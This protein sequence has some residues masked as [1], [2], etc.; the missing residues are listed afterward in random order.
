VSDQKKASLRPVDFVKPRKD[1]EPLLEEGMKQLFESLPQPDE[2]ISFEEDVFFPGQDQQRSGPTIDLHAHA[3]AKVGRAM[4]K[5][6]KAMVYSGWDN[7]SDIIR[8][9]VALLFLTVFRRNGSPKIKTILGGIIAEREIIRR[10]MEE[11]GL[12][13]N[14]ADAEKAATDAAAKYGAEEARDFLR[15]TIAAA[16][17]SYPESR[18]KKVH[19]AKLGEL[20]E[21]WTKKCS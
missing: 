18:R 19:L 13:D 14:L 9:A 10:Q 15:D 8:S 17:N 4:D 6:I 20:L 7:R 12:A 1:F 11:N 21:Y 2:R 5:L 16:Q 3:P